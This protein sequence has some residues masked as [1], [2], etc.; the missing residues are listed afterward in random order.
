MPETLTQ[1]LLGYALNA[2]PYNSLAELWPV[3]ET[4]APRIKA[5]CFPDEEFPIEVRFSERI[6]AELL[7]DC[8]HIA[9]LKHLL[10]VHDLR[11]ITVNGFV[12]PPFHG[13]PLKERVYR[14]AWH[15]SAARARFTNACLDLLAQLA[16]VDAPFVSVSVPFGALKP[17]AMDAVAPNILACAEHAAAI[18]QRTGVR[19]VVALEPEPGLCVETTGETIGFFERFVPADRRRHLGVNFDL[20]HQL[21]QFEDPVES[22]ER[23]LRAGVPL[24]KIHLSNAAEFTRFKPFYD[25][26]IYLHQLVGVNARGERVWFSLD[27]PLEPPPREATRFRCHY[28]L[29]V[30]PQPQSPVG[31]TLAEVERF[32]RHHAR[33][34]SLDPAVPFVIETYT[35]VEQ[36]RG[37]DRLVA[38]IC[39]ELDWV[40]QLMRA[41]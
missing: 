31:T 27:W 37:P 34:G 25:D 11:L 7:A 13:Q 19:C 26:S 2:F 5:R 1:R 14:P 21:V 18:E 8:N 15:E 16:P 4:D 39:A 38:N 10:D 17:T 6:V 22:V 35:W 20:S 29:A 30:C 24:A 23:L 3:I 32:V 9:R 36:L 41:A 28:H 33:G 12:M 40:R